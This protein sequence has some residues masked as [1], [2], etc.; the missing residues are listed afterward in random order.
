MHDILEGSLQYEVKELLK[1][2]I[3][4]HKY[5]TLDELNKI[6]NEF[7]Y[8]LSEKATRPAT[9]APNVLASSDHSIKQKGYLQYIKLDHFNCSSYLAAEMWC[10]AWLLPLMVGDSIPEEDSQWKLFLD[11]LSIMDD[12]FA[13]NTTEDIAAYVQQLIGDYLARFKELY[14]HCSIIPKQHYMIHIPEWM[15]KYTSN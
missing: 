11:L 10:L 14:P 6:I 3:Y 12:V 1:H 7:P 4:I 5:L 9:I 13:P 15:E 2:F 8:V